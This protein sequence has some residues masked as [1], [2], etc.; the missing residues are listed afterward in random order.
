LVDAHG[1]SEIVEIRLAPLTQNTFLSRNQLWY[2][3]AE[4]S[5]L[6]SVD[7][8]VVDGPPT[9]TDPE[10]RFPALPAFWDQL[11]PSAML[12]L[13][14]AS[15]EGEKRIAQQWREEYPSLAADWVKTS[16]GLLVLARH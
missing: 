10:I 15:R 5:D 13:D 4:L 16:R 1:L 3:T 8:L 11:S 14:D 12:L 6:A 2:D 7:L 9:D